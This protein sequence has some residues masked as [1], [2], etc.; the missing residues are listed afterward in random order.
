[1]LAPRFV[2][3]D[4][5]AKALRI[6]RAQKLAS[7]ATGCEER[8]ISAAPAAPREGFAGDRGAIASQA[9]LISRGRHS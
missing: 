3:L 6:L 1:M 5:S 7:G 2:N 4:R 9:S 8:A